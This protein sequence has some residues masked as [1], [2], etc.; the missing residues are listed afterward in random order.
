LGDRIASLAPLLQ[1]MSISRK[2]VQQTA[3]YGGQSGGCQ[4]EI[5]SMKS[6]SVRAGDHNSTA[7]SL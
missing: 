7:A 1:K 3:A 5:T 6:G 2:L 4:P